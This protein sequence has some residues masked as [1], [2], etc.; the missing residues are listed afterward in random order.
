VYIEEIPGPQPIQGVSTSTTG[1]VGVTLKGPT[2]GKPE[3]VTSFAEFNEKFGGFID[4]PK[5]DAERLRWELNDRE[6]GFWWR[7]PLAVKGFFDNGG[8]RLFVKRV[9]SS[10]ATEA[11]ASIPTSEVEARPAGSASD[12]L[13]LATAT[14][15]PAPT[16][17]L[18][19]VAKAEGSWGNDLSVRVRPVRARRLQAVL[20]SG[21]PGPLA[22]TLNAEIPKGTTAA[23]LN[24][25]ARL[26]T[27][28]GPV[29]VEIARERFEVTTSTRAR[30]CW[31]DRARARH[32][33]P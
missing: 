7:F 5:D 16:D 15:T 3:L 17:L 1:M 31:W 13:R 6:G 19:A 28:T 10:L 25:P 22:T 32:G 21:L 33:R 26:G 9:V 4:Q 29:V 11:E 18:R 12:P 2:D 24:W 8:R 20:P 27:L 23:I 30:W 14:A